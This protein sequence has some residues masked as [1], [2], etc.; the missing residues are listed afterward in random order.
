MS[1][2]RVTPQ[3][4]RKVVAATTVKEMVMCKDKT[5]HGAGGAK[6]LRGER[7]PIPLHNCVEVAGG[8]HI[9]NYQHAH[10]LVKPVLRVQ[11]NVVAHRD[12]LMSKP[13]SGI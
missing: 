1:S 7:T 10:R 4:D 12:T 11:V 3:C 9:E 6:T 13:T 8:D 5:E 2:N